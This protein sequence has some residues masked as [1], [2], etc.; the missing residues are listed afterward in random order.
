MPSAALILLGI[1]S[2]GPW[3]GGLPRGGGEREITRTLTSDSARFE[4]EDPWIIAGTLIVLAK[5][6][7]LRAGVDLSWSDSLHIIQFHPSDRLS[8]GDTLTIIYRSAAVTDK[9]L[10]TRFPPD[11][12]DSAICVE[13]TGSGR[14]IGGRTVEPLPGWSGLRHSGTVTRGVRFGGTGGSVTSGMHLEL[15]GRPKRGVT[16]DAV[17]D[18]RGIPATARG[19]SATL[20]ELDRV[21]FR[22]TTPHLEAELGDWDLDWQRGRYCRIARQLKGGRIAAAVGGL[23]VEAAVAGG[24]NS[25]QHLILEGR[26]GDQGPYEL[27]DGFGR[28]GVTVAAGSER[29]YLNG[30]RLKNGHGADYVIDYPRGTITFN[31]GVLIRDDSRIEVEYEYSDEV[32]PRYLNAVRAGWRTPPSRTEVSTCLLYTSP[33][34]RDLSTARMPSSA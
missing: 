4:I 17:L 7:T 25:Y 8:R 21:L 34:P 19:G 14:S 2:S 1:L 12:A 22:V 31:P 11:S 30:R 27:V 10:F 26:A 32:Y 24:G 15:S 16:V 20:A 29:V 13:N 28:P 5:G 23:E 33:S 6:D 9:L 3:G 18:D